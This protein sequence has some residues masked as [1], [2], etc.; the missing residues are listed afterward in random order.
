MPVMA[1]PPN[2]TGGSPGRTYRYAQAPPL[3]PFGFGLAYTSFAYDA[4]VVEAASPAGQALRVGTAQELGG[5]RA[6]PQL[7]GPHA[8]APPLVPP[9]AGLN[10]TVTLRN[11]GAVASGEV[12]QLYL[13]LSASAAAGLP[14]GWVSPRWWLAEFDRVSVGAGGSVGL[15]FTLPPRALAVVNGSAAAT[16]GQD[17]AITGADDAQAV[18]SGAAFGLGRDYAA[19]AAALGAGAIGWDDSE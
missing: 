15:A 19:E 18:L 2:A 9:C 10:V 6:P 17:F 12:V 8:S 7:R 3:L 5:S 16:F 13:N 11:T 4:P 1:L 14:A